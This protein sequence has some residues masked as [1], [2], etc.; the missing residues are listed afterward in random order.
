M[1]KWYSGWWAAGLLA[2]MAIPAG[3][4]GGGADTP[5]PASRPDIV[6]I[7]T[8]DLDADAVASMPQVQALIGDQG[9][10]MERHMVSLS[11]CCPSRTSI[12]RGQYVHNHR[13]VSN[14]EATGGGWPTFRARGE[15]NDCLPVWLHNTGVTTALFGKYLNEYPE[16]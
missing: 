10:R 4:G 9:L 2:L 8:D 15:Q 7:L 16:R 13:V 12:M 6:F 3:C 5:R 11:L 1:G 14:T